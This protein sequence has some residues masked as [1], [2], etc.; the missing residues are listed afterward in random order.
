MLPSHSSARPAPAS[1]RS[2]QPRRPQPP[3][4]PPPTGVAA[5]AAPGPAQRHSRPSRR[6]AASRPARHARP[7]LPGR[8]RSHPGSA[9]APG[10]APRCARTGALSNGPFRPLTRPA[11][12][13]RPFIPRPGAAGAPVT[14]GPSPSSAFG[15]RRGGQ[16]RA[17]ATATTG[18]EEGPRKETAAREGAAAQEAAARARPTGAG[19]PCSRRSRFPTCSPCKSSRPR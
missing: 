1:P 12:G 14:P 2:P 16:R 17:R 4:Q 3:T 5:S 10:Q 8:G 13:P 11:G 7:R 18:L 15:R 9:A 6:C 19:P